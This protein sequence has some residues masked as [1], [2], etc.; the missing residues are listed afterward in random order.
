MV[1][2][3]SKA[4]AFLKDS[5]TTVPLLVYPDSNKP[6]TLYTDAS[7]TC[8]GDCLTQDCDGNE[9][10]IYYLSHKL[11]KSQCKWSVVEKEAYAIH[12]ALQKLDFYLHN[13]QFVIKTDHKPLK[14]LLESPMQNKKIQLWALSMSGDNCSIEY[15]AGTTNSCADLLSRQPGKTNPKISSES[16][17]AEE[18]EDQYTIDVND[19]LFEVNDLDS[20]QFDPK[21]FVSC[22]LPNDE[23]FEKCD[24]SDFRNNGFDMKIEQSR[25]DDISEIR[26]II[27]NG[28][29]NKDVQKHYLLVDDLVYC[30]SNVNDDPCLRLFIPK[31][32]RNFVVIQDHDKN[33]HMGVQKTFDSI[34][35]RYYWPNLFKEINQYVPECT[36]CKTRSLQKIGL[37]LQETDIPPY[38][39]A[40]VSLD[41]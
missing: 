40:R 33:G 21:A 7:D 16:Q 13:A 10:P 37:P 30:L 28:N 18:L 39:M 11:S 1:R 5:L 12:F 22:D 24:C 32:L 41:L 26:S 35:K 38:P 2:H 29:E 3:T 17:N 6:Y 19:N 23:S 14:Y 36:V 34:R 20:T 9:K 31:H 8:T 27:L 4:F 25:D 15:I